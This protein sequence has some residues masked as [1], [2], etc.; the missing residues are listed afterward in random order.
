MHLTL[1]FGRKKTFSVE[2]W[3]FMNTIVNSNSKQLKRMGVGIGCIL[4]LNR[5]SYLVRTHHCHASFGQVRN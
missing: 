2:I 5:M 3:V 4:R 1:G